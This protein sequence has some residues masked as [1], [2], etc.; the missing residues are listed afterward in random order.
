MVCYKIRLISLNC[1]IGSELCT[2][3]KTANLA[4]I[5]LIEFIHKKTNLIHFIFIIQHSHFFKF[6]NIIITHNS[7]KTYLFS[8]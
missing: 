2:Q 5:L 6:K 4:I 1:A 3:K 7:L 8:F